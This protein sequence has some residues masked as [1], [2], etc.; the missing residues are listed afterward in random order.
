LATEIDS[1]LLGTVNAGLYANNAF[2]LSGL[3]V[4]A[5]SRDIRRRSEQL[6]VMSQLGTDTASGT[7]PGQGVLPLPEPP[8][9]TA[10]ADALERLRDPSRRLVDELFWFWPAEGDGAMEALRRGDADAATNIWESV[11]GGAGPAAAVAVHNLAVLAHVRALAEPRLSAEVKELWQSAFRHWAS[12]SASDA[13][14]DLVTSRIR[15]MSDPRLTPATARQMR[16]ALPSVLLSINAQLALRASREG[17]PV[18]AAVHVS[19]MVGSGF[20]AE[21]VDRV[22]RQHAEPV[23]AQLRSMSQEAERSA[24]DPRRGAEAARR[25]LDQAKPLFE[26]LGLYLA[27]EHSLLQGIMDEIASTALR[28]VVAY[29]NET[30]ALQAGREVLDLALP[31]AATDAARNRIRDNLGI[32]ETRTKQEQEQRRLVRLYGTCWFDKTNA[33]AREDAYPQKM[34]GNVQR[35]R[36]SVQ[37]TQLSWNGNTINIP[38]CPACRKAHAM[39]RRRNIVVAW[40]VFLGLMT[41]AAVSIAG[42]LALVAALLICVGLFI[43]LPVTIGLHGRDG[44]PE[45]Q[46]KTLPDF[47]PIKALLASGWHLGEKPSVR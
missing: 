25:L 6:R 4:S 5:T 13:F 42:N 14:W 45:R 11:S 47:E 23:L 16:E 9:V 10:I 32:L 35:R 3:P 43:V 28:C 39:R 21:A 36:V 29:V 46:R 27:A 41:L 17:L 7:D 15:E 2:R 31:V 40:L 1:S 18:D 37:A 44:V 12:V 24:S 26:D 38:R 22:L 34:Y 20:G 30:G 33:A 8:G 19:L